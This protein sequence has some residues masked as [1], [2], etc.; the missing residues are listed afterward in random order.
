MVRVRVRVR[1][2][3]LQVKFIFKILNLLGRRI[4]LIVDY[5]LNYSLVSDRSLPILRKSFVS[6]L[7]SSLFYLNLEA[8][9]LLL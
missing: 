6:S 5:I 2:S 9:F 3:M 4:T 1:F 8:L 7:R